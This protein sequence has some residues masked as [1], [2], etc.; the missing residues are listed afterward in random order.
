MSDLKFTNDPKHFGSILPG[1]LYYK[2]KFGSWAI[3]WNLHSPWLTLD[4]FGSLWIRFEQYMNKG[5]ESMFSCQNEKEI[6]NSP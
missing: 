4:K 1:I 2:A 5:T 6:K 3:V